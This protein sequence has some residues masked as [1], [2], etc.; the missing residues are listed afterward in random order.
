MVK[1]E[2]ILRY[3]F[4]AL[5]NQLSKPSQSSLWYQSTAV[6]DQ[7]ITLQFQHLHSQAVEQPFD[8]WLDNAR[9]SL[10]YVILLDQLP[11]NMFRGT[12]KAFASDLSALE[13]VKAGVSQGFDKKL[14]LIERIFY[15][16]P[17]E[18]SEDLGVQQESVKLFR[19]LLE[20]FPSEI[21][22]VVIQVA[23]DFAIEHLE[24][25]EQFGRFP[26]RNN[27]LNR[28]STQQELDYL[29][30]GNDFGQSAKG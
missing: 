19:Q 15:Y 23:L 13:A 3:W 28:Q 27:V 26:H 24:I 1:A 10:A 2:Q 6:I 30:S 21:H 16:H 4:G 5:D 22:Q 8:H 17:F 11:R 7:E 29:K 18:H 20:D 9:G 25:I 12:E 14:A